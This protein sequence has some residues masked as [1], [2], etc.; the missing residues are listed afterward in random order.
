MNKRKLFNVLLT[1]TFVIA[2]PFFANAQKA[3]WQNLDLQTD[4]TFGIST[5]KAYKELLKG[6]KL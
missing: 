4:S 5:E 1:G 6:K 3:N 2:I